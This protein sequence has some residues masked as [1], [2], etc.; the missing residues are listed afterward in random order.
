MWNLSPKGG[1]CVRT[2]Q[3]ESG[4]LPLGMP[5]FASLQVPL[6]TQVPPFLPMALVLGLSLSPDPVWAQ[7]SGGWTVEGNLGREGPSI[8]LV[9]EPLAVN[10]NW[11]YRIAIT[12]S[13]GHSQSL[14]IRNGQ[15][16][17]PGD[18]RLTDINADGL[19]DL[20]VIG[21]KDHRGADWFK[22]WRFDARR[23][24][25]VWLGD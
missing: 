5:P 22:T 11:Q 4:P 1:L 18:V 21:G 19:L 2:V 9:V 13:D 6:T 23:A 20:M 10:A 3:H 24:M 15:A 16:L 17:R 8:R 14:E 12:L 25:F 7:A